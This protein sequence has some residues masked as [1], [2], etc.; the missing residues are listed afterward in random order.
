MFFITGFSLYVQASVCASEVG[1]LK[2]KTLEYEAK[3]EEQKA[4][5]KV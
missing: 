5:V 2:A 4:Q 1:K 3:L